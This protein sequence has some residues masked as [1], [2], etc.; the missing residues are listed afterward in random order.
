MLLIWVK[1]MGHCRVEFFGYDVVILKIRHLFYT[2]IV[3][4]D[5]LEL[6]LIQIGYLS[7]ILFFFVERCLR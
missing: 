7:S 2:K 5:F 6:K 4:C 1:R 3:I